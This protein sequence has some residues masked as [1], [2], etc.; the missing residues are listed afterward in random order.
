VHISSSPSHCRDPRHSGCPALGDHARVSLYRCAPLGNVLFVLACSL[1]RML[2]RVAAYDPTLVKRFDPVWHVIKSA[3]IYFD[4]MLIAA[5]E[6]RVLADDDYSDQTHRQRQLNVAIAAFIP[7]GE[8]LQ[9]ERHVPHL[10]IAAPP[11]LLRDIALIRLSAE[12]PA[13]LSKIRYFRKAA[14]RSR[15]AAMAAA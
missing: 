4:L 6:A 10:Q 14:R 11:Q 5:E 12:T 13:C 2:P 7:V 3:E 8:V 15:S 9:E 1:S